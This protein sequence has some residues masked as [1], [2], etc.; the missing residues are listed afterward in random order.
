MPLLEVEALDTAYGD[1]QVLFGISLSVE[2]G[3]VVALLGRNGAGKTTT[4]SSVIGLVPARAGS[5]R[6]GGREL[7]GL[8]PH[9]CCRAGLGFVAEDCRLFPGLTVAENFEAARRPGRADRRRGDLAHVLELFPDLPGMLHR[10]AGSLSGGQQRMVAI[11]RTLMGNPDLLLL[12]E[13]S[14]GLAPL[15]I[16]ALLRRLRAL[17]QTGATVLL[18]EQNLRFA[19]ELA[20]RVYIIEKGE[21]R[22]HGTPAALAAHPEVRQRY[23]M[24]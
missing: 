9:E 24:V 13:P 17:K 12:D 16:D 15:M 7:R 4:L 1:S 8:E 22:Y 23:L 5:I 18:S 11:A 20:E 21:I 19:T 14:E 10:L 3:E 2:R 6:F